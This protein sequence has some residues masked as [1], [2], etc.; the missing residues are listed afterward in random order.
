[1]LN[2]TN[3]VLQALDDTILS[4]VISTHKLKHAS[5]RTTEGKILGF[6][7]KQE[8]VESL[9][10]QKIPEAKSLQNNYLRKPPLKQNPAKIYSAPASTNLTSC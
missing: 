3:T 2:A 1:M 4:T 9:E 7:G 10:K 8:M 6:L 5:I